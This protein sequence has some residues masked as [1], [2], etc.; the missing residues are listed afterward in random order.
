MIIKVK[1]KHCGEHTSIKVNAVESL[2][3]ENEK[4]RNE[5]RDLKGLLN[6]YNTGKSN[7]KNPF[8]DIFK[9]FM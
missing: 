4:L 8:E 2:T 3:K 6:S 7:I 1:C 5:L 9:G